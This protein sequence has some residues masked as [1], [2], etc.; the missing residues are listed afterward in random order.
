LLASSILLGEKNDLPSERNPIQ[1]KSTGSAVYAAIY[2]PEGLIA[3]PGDILGPVA[4]ASGFYI[5]DLCS[6]KVA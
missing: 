4:H 6:A 3:G 1:V 2:N 5:R